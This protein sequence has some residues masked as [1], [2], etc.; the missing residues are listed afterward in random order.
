MFG[1]NKVI[2]SGSPVARSC[3]AGD[4]RDAGRWSSA[5]IH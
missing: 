1:T 3:A 2:I 5:E 4:G